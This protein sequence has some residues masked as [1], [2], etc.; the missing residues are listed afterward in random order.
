VDYEQYFVSQ[1]PVV[2]TVVTQVCRRN[3]LRDAEAEEFASEVKLRLIE[4]DYEVLRRFQRRSSI[5]TYLTVVI[6]RLFLNYRNQLWG[7]WRP[8]VEAARLG[9]AA[10]LLERLIA[11]DG[12]SF[13]EAQEQMRLNHGV[14]ESRDALY[15]V[16]VKLPPR[17]AGR[18][19][20]PED[21]AEDVPSGEA[22]PELTIVRAEREFFDHRASVALDR[23]RETLTAEE[24]LLLRMR[25][26]DG[27]QV[28]QIAAVLHLPQKPL[29]RTFER[30]FARLREC[31]TSDGISPADIFDTDRKQGGTRG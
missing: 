12:W 18:R 14:L 24:R 23:A 22:S 21:L 4:R 10:V 26:D 11:R 7:R 6:Q 20:V 19:S 3:H 5:H 1:L 16:W 27:F 15:A 25:F 9:P 31:L 2:D 30:L 29:Y 13:D 28:S 17:A 8:S